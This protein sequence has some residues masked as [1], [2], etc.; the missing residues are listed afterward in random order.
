MQETGVESTASGMGKAEMIE[1]VAGLGGDEERGAKQ[2]CL[3]IPSY[4]WISLALFVVLVAVG[5]IGS[6][7][8]ARSVSS[9]NQ[10][11]AQSIALER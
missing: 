4:I 10:Q 3:R 9:Q 7:Y 5:C 1:E 8:Y 6:V 11:S 2:R